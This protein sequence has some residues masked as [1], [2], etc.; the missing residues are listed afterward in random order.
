MEAF[1]ILVSVALL[2]SLLS[3]G[4]TAEWEGNYNDPRHPGKCTISPSLVLNSG[5]SIKDPTHECRRIVCGHSGRA[6][7]QSCG[8]SILSP[9]CRYG[10]YINTDL[11][12]PDCCL[13]TVLCN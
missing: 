9:P 2:V 7:F 1:H 11:P 10:G 4:Q 13:R 3:A 6:L 5:V 12:Y 8:V